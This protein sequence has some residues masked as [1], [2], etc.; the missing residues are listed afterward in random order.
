M[1]SSRGSAQWQPRMKSMGPVRRA[2]PASGA[3]FNIE[4]GRA[5]MTSRCLWHA[6]RALALGIVLMLLGAGMATIG[7]YAEHLSIGQ[8]VRGNA[9]IRVKN[10]SRGFHL[11]N[12]S[13]VG[14]IIM[15]FGGFIV[16]AACVMTFEARD[17]AAKV[18]PARFKM[19]GSGSGGG[20]R[21]NGR[22]ASSSRRATG[23]AATPTP[24]NPNRWEQHMGLFRTAGSSGE[25]APSRQALTAA[26]IHFSKTLGSPEVSSPVKP[27][28]V[29]RSGSVPNLADHHHHHH[30][31][32]SPKSRTS[33]RRSRNSSLVQRTTRESSGERFLHP[34]MLQYH[35]QALSVD[36][37][38]PH[39]RRES[40]TD[41]GG[42]VRRSDTAKKRILARQK[43]I[44]R[45]EELH[46]PRVGYSSIRRRSS[47]TSDA[48]AASRRTVTRRASSTSRTPSIDSRSVHS[49]ERSPRT[50]HRVV[51]QISTPS[52]DRDFRS[53][54]SIS[55]EPMRVLSCQSSIEPCVPEEEGLD[56]EDK[57]TFPTDLSDSSEKGRTPRPDSLIL[58]CNQEPVRQKFLYRSKS[59]KSFKR[60][61]VKAPVTEFHQIYFISSNPAE[62]GYDS[63]EVIDERRMKNFGTSVTANS[64]QLEKL[65][66]DGPE[67]REEGH[68][69]P[70]TD[71]RAVCNEGE[72]SIHES[73]INPNQITLTIQAEIERQV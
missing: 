38:N 29:S 34:G 21:S 23:V 68:K 47:T 18:V 3:T 40:G 64:A 58:D 66:Y 17:S 43:P 8:E 56:Q 70:P 5:K 54:L 33:H 24:V 25:K 15:G 11:N 48:S 19:G 69:S 57:D 55:S 1:P 20:S 71:S 30:H 37:G 63:I 59:S 39:G 7:Y 45:E 42:H 35:R 62:D 13:Y 61:K 32:R 50:P 44:E 26:L 27:R 14:P 46:S 41:Q 9:T 16:V 31:H 4:V 28:K 51:A 2:C 72:T 36:E 49:P 73:N 53:Q 22:S 6:C 60:P 10:E 65:L 12:L 52:V 67:R